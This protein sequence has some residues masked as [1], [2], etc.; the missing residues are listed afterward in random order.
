M[1]MAK[2]RDLDFCCLQESRWKRGGARVMGEYKCFWS[3]GKDGAGGVAVLVASK[4]QEE[5][6]DVKRVSERIML[7]RIRVGKRI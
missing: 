7:V 3:G 5:V 1:D 2:R 4:W 6:T